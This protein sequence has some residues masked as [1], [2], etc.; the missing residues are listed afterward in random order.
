[1]IAQTVRALGWQFDGRPGVLSARDAGRLAEPTKRFLNAIGALGDPF[2]M[3]GQ[4]SVPEWGRNL[5][6]MGLRG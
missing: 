3:R 2:A 6:R 4:S 1:M 5:A